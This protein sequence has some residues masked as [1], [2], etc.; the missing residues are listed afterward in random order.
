[1]IVLKSTYRNLQKTHEELFNKKVNLERDN[2]RLA[3][4]NG[5][6]N[7][8]VDTMRIKIESLDKYLDR[9][10][11]KF[12][13]AELMADQEYPLNKIRESID[14][15]RMVLYPGNSNL[16]AAKFRLDVKLKNDRL[17]DAGIIP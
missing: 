7:A 14:E 16:S 2:D 13:A 1:M 8:T 10:K 3:R 6:M 5:I 15:L 9:V 4:E 17:R 12:L 11:E